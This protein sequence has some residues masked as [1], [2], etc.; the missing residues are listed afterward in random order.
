M[1]DILNFKLPDRLYNPEYYINQEKAFFDNFNSSIS[2]LVEIKEA[3]SVGPKPLSLNGLDELIDKLKDQLSKGTDK[4]SSRDLR[5]LTYALFVKPNRHDKSIGSDLKLLQHFFSLLIENWKY[6]YL[7]GLLAS[8]FENWDIKTPNFQYILEYILD[9]I[10][11]S[12]EPRRLGKFFKDNIDFLDYTQGSELLGMY[13]FEQGI[14]IS[15]WDKHIGIYRGQMQNKYF[16][17][18]IKIYMYF[19]VDVEP[20]SEVLIDKIVEVTDEIDSEKL[21]KYGFCLLIDKLKNT[22]NNF[23]ERKLRHLCLTHIG[24]PN[25]DDL[26]T[27]SEFT[28]IN[29]QALINAGRNKLKYWVTQEFINVFFEKCIKAP[30]RKK[31][32][33]KYAE[34]IEDFRVFGSKG[35]MQRLLYID[36]ITKFV[37]NRFGLTGSNVY[38]LKAAF[39]FVIKGFTIVEYS[40]E[41]DAA[42]FFDPNYHYKPNILSKYINKVEDLK[43]NQTSL[44]LIATNRGNTIT[45]INHTGRLVHRDSTIT[46]EDKAHFWFSE[47]VKI[48]V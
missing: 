23:L 7:N 13:L 21:T 17:E 1:I 47:I 9:R 20:L 37:D 35:L 33:M 10:K 4:I 36:S 28:N 42:Y 46:W 15:K 27:V 14:P 12:K 30:D 3:C 41:G 18:S 22:N 11:Q 25:R 40:D 26:W 48:K 38:T 16:T 29:D 2:K 19:I 45:D 8:I 6:K 5:T 31:F 39:V 24:D 44:P 43:G 34:H 32:W